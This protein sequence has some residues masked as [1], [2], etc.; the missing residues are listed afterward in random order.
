MIKDISNFIEDLVNGIDRSMVGKYN[1][2]LEYTEICDTKYSRIGKSVTDEALDTFLITELDPNKWIKAGTSNGKLTLPEPYFL[3]GTRISANREWTI[4]TS[5][6]TQKTPIIWLLS[7]VRYEKFGRESVYEWESDVR[8]FFL[9]EGDGVNYY[10][11]DYVT[12]VVYPMSRLAELFIDSVKANRQ[13]K[14]LDQWEIINF[15]RFGTEDTKG[16]IQNILD[17][18]LSGVELTITLTKYKENCKC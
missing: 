7:D 14:T 12:N 1:P 2:A 4:S 9:D 13:Y 10:S 11:A 15:T 18:N 16:Y 17:A 8:L 6:L 3:S 5:D